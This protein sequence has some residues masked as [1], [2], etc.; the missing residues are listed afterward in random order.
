MLAAR[1]RDT[2][3]ILRAASA[4]IEEGSVYT[5]ERLNSAIRAINKLGIFERV[6]R[7]DCRVTRSKTNP[8]TVDIEVKLKAKNPPGQSPR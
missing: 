3:K 7:S 6:A 1:T 4:P 2:D 5:T 8:G